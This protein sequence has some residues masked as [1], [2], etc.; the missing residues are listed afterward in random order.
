MILATDLFGTG[1][2]DGGG[3]D[4]GERLL[5]GS[6]ELIVSSSSVVID[7]DGLSINGFIIESELGI[8]TG[9]SATLSGSFQTDV[10]DQ[11]SASFVSPLISTSH[12]L[13][14]VVGS[15]YDAVNFAADLTFTFTVAGQ[16]GIYEGTISSGGRLRAASVEPPMWPEGVSDQ[17]LPLLGD[18]VAW[19]AQ[20][21]QSS[22][23]TS[24]G[25]RNDLDP[26]AVDLLMLG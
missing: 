7:P 25:E 22:T 6:P 26:S 16:A 11:I 17:D 5:S 14:D 13:G 2:Y 9:D 8:F 19:L 18:A 12:N 20:L 4:G 10:D 15:A 24:S 23:F 1:T 3:R 21:N